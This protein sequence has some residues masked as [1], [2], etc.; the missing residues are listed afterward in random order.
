MRIILFTG[1]GGV[2]KTTIAAATAHRAAKAGYKTLIISTDPAHSLSDAL[3]VELG[4]EPT[5]VNE[6]LEGQELDVYYSMKKYWGNMRQLMLQVLRWQGMENMLAEEM[7]VLPGMEEASAFLWLEKFYEEDEYDLIVIDSAPT[8]ETL[9]LLTL[10]QVSKWWVSKAFPF[11][12]TTVK[13]VGS[14]I[15]NVTGVPVDRGYM[16]LE[17]IFDKLEKI[18]KVFAD[19]EVSSI[20]LV[21]NPERMVVQEAK[22]AFT[23]L[24]LYG[25]NVDA[26]V[27]NKVLPQ[28]EIPTAF[29]KYLVSQEKY[30]MEIENSF[31][32]LPIFKVEHAGE[33]VFGE[34][35][36]TNIG[37]QIYGKN[38]PT[39]V[40]FSEKPFQITELKNAFEVK[41]KLPLVKNTDFKVRKSGDE[42]IIQLQNQR[43]NIFLPRF[44]HFYEMGSCTYDNPW[45]TV[46]LEAS[47]ER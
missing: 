28:E 46:R 14:I 42:L 3:D 23:Y 35:L 12:K 7:A 40:Y 2:G 4:P 15:R 39:K 13:T 26:V 31:S 47:E 10:P 41:V 36:L 44:T 17:N 29:S 38:D 18:Q 32:P 8:G 6:N 27:V 37:E 34:K 19:P 33:E 22:R 30:L 25:Y 24:Q 5:F 16:E 11:Q 1:K 9:T 43:K 21:A 45:L 20:R